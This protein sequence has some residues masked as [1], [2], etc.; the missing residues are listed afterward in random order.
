M[1]GVKAKRLDCTDSMQE[2]DIVSSFCMPSSPIASM[3]FFDWDRAW[4]T[5]A[6]DLMGLMTTKTPPLS[7]P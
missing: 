5:S 1:S 6:R 3:N 2:A 7:V 4:S